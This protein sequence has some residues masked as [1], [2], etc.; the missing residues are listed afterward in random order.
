MVRLRGC[1]QEKGEHILSR[2]IVQ[3]IM[4][5]HLVTGDMTA[6][7]EIGIRIDHTL[8]HD[9]TGQM[10]ILQ[11]EALGIPRVKTI[12]SLVY[13]DH[14]T[15]QIGFENMDD[16]R[17]LASAA[18][19]YGLWFSPA[20]NGICHQVNLER[21][22]VPGDTL[23]GADSHTT[24]GGGVG[25]LAI[26]AGGLDVAVAMA[27][28]P[29]YLTMPRVMKVTLTGHLRPW[30]SAKDVILE[31]LRRITVSGGR[32]M[33]LEF[34]GEGLQGISAVGRA[35][36]ANMSI[37][38]GAF[39]SVFPSDDI[40]RAY[41]KAQGREG[42][43]KELS[44]DPGAPYDDEIEIN[45]DA[46]TPLVAKPHS[47]DNVVDVGEVEGLPVQQVAIGSC[48]NSSLEDMLKVAEILKRGTV[49]PGV[50]LV[51]APGSRQVLLDLAA[52]GA[53]TSMI[54]AGARIVESACGFCVGVGQ[55]PCTDGVSLRTSNRNFYGR[56]G[57]RSAGVYLVSPETAAASALFGRITDPRT[58][59]EPPVIALP[60]C[61]KVDDR[62]VIPPEEDGSDTELLR[63]PNIAPLPRFDALPDTVEGE[64]LISLDDNITTDDIIP[65]G[66]AILSLRANIPAISAYLFN[67]IDPTFPERAASAGTGFIVGG[68][69]YG[70][71]SSREH[72]ALCPRYLGIRAVI[73]ESYARIHKSNLVNFGILPLEL[74][75][76][77]DKADFA[78]GDLLRLAGLRERLETNAPV[79]VENLSSGKSI[80]TRLDL[81]TRLKKIL[82]A[83]GLL[84]FV[85]QGSRK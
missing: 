24:T 53:L 22:S 32:G 59:G 18:R 19:K 82:L 38:T 4:E 14:N 35:T 37:E 85:Q 79:M 20:G 27:G 17:F 84:A 29:F 48:T 15:L 71:G 34:A 31:I 76:P 44:A 26:G 83:G 77:A 36:I 56:S 25:M 55:A 11:F 6:G 75:N 16:H 65:A 5:Q 46:L 8:I 33:I 10:A 7:A 68:R 64:M 63:G 47:P 72:A 62:M 54:E 57:T 78:P 12:R 40:T 58:L 41:F 28:E 61:F 70:Q 23:L 66:T 60:E 45:L 42:D 52:S 80:E 51:I 9:A 67:R 13:I 1:H 49:A 39:T 2:N 50:S 69:N 43:W 81:S 74:V 73:A 30:T 3:K 21:F